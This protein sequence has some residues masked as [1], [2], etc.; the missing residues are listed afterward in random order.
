M[1]KLNADLLTRFVARIAIAALLSLQLVACSDS[2]TAPN[3]RMDRDAVENILPAIND[4]RRRI[5]SGFAD[6]AVRQQ[7]TIT[8][9]EIEIALRA[10]DVDG[11][12]KNMKAVANLMTQYS[13]H[14]RSDRPEV[15]AVFLVMAGVERVA[16][17]GAASS[18]T[19]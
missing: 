9:A 5:A 10:D 3:R 19:Y 1:K 14:A 17:P 6:V 15:T 12:E 7:L 8:L 16:T 11:V 18:F 2:M 13:A 4:A